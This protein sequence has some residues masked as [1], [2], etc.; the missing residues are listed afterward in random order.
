M[1]KLQIL[2]FSTLFCTNLVYGSN[3]E[4]DSDT[5]TIVPEFVYSKDI[6][7]QHLTNN[8]EIAHEQARPHYGPPYGPPYNCPSC[9]TLPV[10][11]C[12]RIT[13][14]YCTDPCDNL[15]CNHIVPAGSKCIESC[16]DFLQNICTEERKE[17][18]GIY[19]QYSYNHC[20]KPTC[21]YAICIP[22]RVTCY[23]LC[24]IWL[25]DINEETE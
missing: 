25:A 20:L 23:T 7:S 16:S 22:L 12:K 3:N 4:I 8:H 1:K 5:E 6:E 15:L 24:C 18:C 21:R 14:N 19:T 13:R 10:S 17:Q 11:K 9:I 2:L